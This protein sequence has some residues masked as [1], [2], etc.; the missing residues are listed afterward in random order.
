VT[1]GPWDAAG[2]YDRYIGRYGP[3]LSEAL[4]AFAGVE[5]GMRALDVGCGPG[6]L[7]AALAGRLGA[8][9]VAAAEPSEAFA[10]ACRARVPGAEV[11]VARAEA[12]PFAGGAFDAALSQLVVN[13][14]AD[15]PAGVREMA[16]VVRPGGAVAACVWDYGGG[17]TLLDAF[18][19]AACE[20]EPG[21][22]ASADEGTAMPYRRE[23]ELAALWREAGVG[24][25]RDGA[26][27]ATAAYAGFDDL[28]APLPAGVGPSGAFC[29]SL[30][31]E[32]RAALREG[33]RRR[34]GVGDGPFELS[35]RAWVAAG[36]A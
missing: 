27:T 13:F 26:L 33:L 21:R 28:W 2:A 4:I 1:A 23:G 9:R 22:A 35:A 6:A 31:E 15:A 11:V 12:L 34:L 5:P 17:M 30:D 20:V 32:G 10:A 14:M 8:E 29:A 36:T 3:S 24:E 16:R 18:W 7:T 25:V 19:D